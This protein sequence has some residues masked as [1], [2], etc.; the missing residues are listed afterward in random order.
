MK[1]ETRIARICTNPIS[2]ALGLALVGCGSGP[3]VSRSEKALCCQGGSTVEAAQVPTSRWSASESIT[4]SP[5][6]AP[7][8]RVKTIPAGIKAVNQDGAVVDLQGLKRKPTALSFI[9]TRC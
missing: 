5:W 2:A 8:R 3:D 1:N 9:Y 6:L 7:E 4:A